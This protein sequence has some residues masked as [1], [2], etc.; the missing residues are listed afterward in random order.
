MKVVIRY[1]DMK[2]KKFSE[3]KL[4]IRKYFPKIF[5][6]IEFRGNQVACV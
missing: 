6:G 5:L 2:W 1:Y 4:K 3:Q